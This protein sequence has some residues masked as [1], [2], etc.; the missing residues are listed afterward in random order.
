LAER[1]Q[2][3]PDGPAVCFS[4]RNPTRAPGSVLVAGVK[5]KTM[6][7]LLIIPALLAERFF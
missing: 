5:A 6:T 7:S 3:K 2:F 1:Y 4:K